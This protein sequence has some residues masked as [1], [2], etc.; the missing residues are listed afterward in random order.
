M[1]NLNVGRVSA[2]SRHAGGEFYGKRAGGGCLP[3]DPMKWMM[4]KN[5]PVRAVAERRPGRGY[6]P[7][8]G[9]TLKQVWMVWAKR[10]MPRSLADKPALV[11]LRDSAQPPR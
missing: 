2:P 8:I 6:A 9:Q 7:A 11:K 4:S 10:F 5:A 3:P 1:A